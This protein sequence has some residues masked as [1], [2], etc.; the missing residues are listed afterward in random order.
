MEYLSPDLS[1][2][3][4]GD[5]I[6]G[7]D[8]VQTAGGRAKEFYTFRLNTETNRKVSLPHPQS[9]I[10]ANREEEEVGFGNSGI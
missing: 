3:W 1:P 8:R 2:V 4:S 9:E 7:S 6:L 5:Q 10:H